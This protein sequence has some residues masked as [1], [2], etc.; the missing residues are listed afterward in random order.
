MEDDALNRIE[1]AI[2]TLHLPDSAKNILERFLAYEFP[3]KFINAELQRKKKKTK[4][5]KTE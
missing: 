5:I 1:L 4:K 3:Q 2:K